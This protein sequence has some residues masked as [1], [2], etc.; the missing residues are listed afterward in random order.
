M[1]HSP[2]SP[3]AAGKAEEAALQAKI[4][5]LL[6]LHPK[7]VDL[8]LTRIERLLSA[9]GNPHLRLPPI[10]HIAGTNG[11]GSSAAF[12]RAYLEAAGYSVHVHTSPHLVHWR[13][14]F[15]LGAKHSGKPASAYVDDGL[16]AEILAEV[17]AANKGQP[18]TVFEILTAAAFV[19]FARFPADALVLEVGLGG[20]F[21]ATN[22]IPRPACA[23]I[24]PIGLDHQAF[25]GET[26]A[27]IAA[28]KAGIIKPHCP[29]VLGCQPI[30]AAETVLRRAAEENSAPLSLYG[31]DYKAE[32]AK[33]GWLFTNRDGQLPLPLPALSGAFQLSNAAAALQAVL[34]AGFKIPPAAAA[35][36]MRSV[37]W[38]ARCQ[39]LTHGALLKAIP[40]GA[41]LW[42]D[43]GHN[44]A[45][46]AALA[47]SL[48]PLLR[49]GLK[50][51]SFYLIGALL[52]NK[53]AAHY[54][55]E[56][57]PLKPKL[58]A[59]PILSSDQGAPPPQ[60][61]A[62]AQNLGMQAE[63]AASITQALDKIKAA[64][65][66][67]A[68]PPFILIGGSLYLAGDA[69]AQNGTPPA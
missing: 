60:L 19:L 28:E 11:K 68:P 42:L 69:L 46:A 5:A 22:I 18:I 33:T 44:P 66:E 55:Q 67:T 1:P 8:S 40:A 17:S 25:L 14:R 58:Y 52:Q 43:G 13:E 29:A 62:I 54:L 56:L 12:A 51:R 57:K 6:D 65:A 31:R 26:A 53:D 9:L 63:T 35:A 50:Q 3:P 38:P 48:K 7:C 45:A 41:Q 2:I 30:K 39:R 37:Y 47:A 32:A 36:A 15:R 34:A 49:C 61:Q 23:L 24:M 64:T 20:R 4:A 27:Q 10:I 59:V 21:D 16:L